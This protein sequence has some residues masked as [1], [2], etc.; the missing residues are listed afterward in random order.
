MFRCPVDRLRNWVET[1]AD[2]QQEGVAA[3]LLP[4]PTSYL[5]VRVLPCVEAPMG[6]ST[7]LPAVAGAHGSA[8]ALVLG[9]KGLGWGVT[10]RTASLPIPPNVLDRLN[11]RWTSALLSRVYG[12]KLKTG[13]CGGA[14]S[15]A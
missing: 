14:T 3:V 1:L 6:E 11:I 5:H 12:N 9:L 4:R 7:L 13:V 15:S 8:G 10:Q 2:M